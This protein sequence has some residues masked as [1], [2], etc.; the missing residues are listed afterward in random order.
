VLEYQP[1]IQSSKQLGLGCVDSKTGRVET[2]EEIIEL[3][4]KANSNIP[5]EKL[6]IHPDCGLRS[7]GDR[8]AAKAK[9]INM[10]AAARFAGS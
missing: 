10:V 9:M 1:L 2:V 6:V 8:A 4:H 3:I 5:A 7:L